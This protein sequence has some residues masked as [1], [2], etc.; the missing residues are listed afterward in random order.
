MMGGVRAFMPPQGILTIASYLPRQREVRFIDENV[1][2]PSEA[3]YRWA[4]AVLVSGMR[5]QRPHINLINEMARQYGN[6][7]ALGGPS[8]SG[9]SQYSPNFVLPHLG[10]HVY[11]PT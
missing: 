6:I 9:C 7:T 11:A 2:P 8:L 1:R 4:D 3:D 5:I 10:E